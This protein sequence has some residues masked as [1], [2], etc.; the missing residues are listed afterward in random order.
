[1]SVKG[2]MV[3]SARRFESRRILRISVIPGKRLTATEASH[4]RRLGEDQ[5]QG[6]GTSARLEH[7]R[8]GRLLS[9]RLKSL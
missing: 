7:T 5:Y 2:A 4:L 3:S 8:Q 6:G 1:M 9:P